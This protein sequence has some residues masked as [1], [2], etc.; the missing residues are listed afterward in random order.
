MQADWNEYGEKA[1]TFTVLE[2][3]PEQDSMTKEQEYISRF[4]DGGKQCYNLISYPE[5]SHAQYLS[6][7][8]KERREARK[9]L[10]GK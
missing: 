2:Y 9:V 1:F 10:Q 3:V 7:L 8:W 6:N 5:M 4:Y